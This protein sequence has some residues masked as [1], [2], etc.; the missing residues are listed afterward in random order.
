M[1]VPDWRFRQGRGLSVGGEVIVNSDGYAKRLAYG[2]LRALFSAGPGVSIDAV[3]EI[4][5]T[6]AAITPATMSAL[7]LVQVGAGLSVSVSGT[8]T[9]SFGT[10]AGTVAD[11]GALAATNAAIA[12]AITI[13]GAPVIGP[14][15][16][17]LASA[18][19]R[20]Q[21]DC[22]MLAAAV[23]VIA[24]VAAGTGVMLPVQPRT[25]VVNRGSS[26]LN[27]YPPVGGRIEF[28]ALNAAAQL[29]AGGAATFV[30]ADNAQFYA[31]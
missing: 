22:P 4:S 24:Q 23:N 12:R 13:G 1:S 6:G 8:L 9:P 3:G 29:P 7:G 2:E 19:G 10:V 27:V 31:I 21:A 17:G 18:A 25:T 16:V 28:G 26:E 5:S 14:Q 20:S 11:G 30:T 15:T